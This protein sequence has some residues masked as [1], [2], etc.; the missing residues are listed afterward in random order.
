MENGD[1][2]VMSIFS[3]IIEGVLDPL[4]DFVDEKVPDKKDSERLKTILE[5]FKTS[6]QYK[7]A[8]LQTELIMKDF[9]GNF[10]QKSWRAIVAIM[11]AAAI[12]FMGRD[13]LIVLLKVALSGYVGG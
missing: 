2:T 7:T 9:N 3:K 1:R 4:F 8:E 5:E 13:D 12:V 10:L 11:F 6:T